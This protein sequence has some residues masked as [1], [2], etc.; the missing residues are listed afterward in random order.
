MSRPGRRVLPAF[1]VLLAATAGGQPRQDELERRL[2][3]LAGVERAQALTE[4]TDLLKND[5]PRKAIQ[6]GQEALAFYAAHPD[7]AAQVRTLDEIAWAY[8][9]VSDYPQAIASAEKGR[10]LAEQHADRKGLARALNN[11]G[12]IAQRRGDGATA[13]DLFGKSLAIYR[14]LGSEPEVAAELSN[15]G[16][17]LSSLMADY[18]QALSVQLESLALR[19]RLGDKNAIALSM[20]NIGIIYDRTGDYDKALDYFQ[21]ALELRKNSGAQNRIA[22]TLTNI[23]DVYLEKREYQKAL[24]AQEEGLMLRKRVGDKEGT[25]FSLQRLGKIYLEMGRLDLARVNF[26]D[27]LASAEQTGDKNTQANS[28]IGLADVARGQGRGREAV[29]FA[30]RGLAIA[31][32]AS[33]HDLRRRAWETLSAAQEKAGDAAGALASYK[34][35]KEENDRIFDEEKSRRLEG[36]ERRYQSQKRES[37]LQRLKGDEA[38][39]ERSA[40]RQR[41]QMNLVIGATLLLGILGF[42]AY[43]RHVVAARIAE[44]LSITDTLT[45][46]KNRRFV[47]QTIGAD[48][49]ASQRRRR[50]LRP[51][52]QT[53]DGDLVFLLIDI[54]RFKSVND[55]FGHRAGDAVITQITAVL[56]E[57]CRASDTLA[58]WGGDEFLIVSRFTNR[59]YA[60][61]FAERIRTEIERESFSL[62]DGRSLRRTCSIGFASHPFSLSHPDVLTWEQ[63]VAVA[64]E[65]LYMA[66]RAGSNAWVGAAATNTATEEQLA[67]LQQR[68]ADNLAQLVT[69]GVV[70][71]ERSAGPVSS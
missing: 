33:L 46:L 1:L 68:T 37:E 54:D 14:Q 3:A 57:I 71:I 55:E 61:V 10:D 62:G 32:Q 58:R 20:N 56:R 44:A 42:G 15:T 50:A 36:L 30:G 49:A 17:V 65:A 26:T 47:L 25:A 12:V 18:D 21:K 9:I 2:P 45:G 6:Y 31:Q 34:H 4:L 13:V 16:F 64:D 29:Q 22:A 59:R 52:E 24:D 41:F 8:M 35:F 66:K 70:V 19:E 53:T 67:Q 39:R 7:P 28:L 38:V 51:G 5:A 69:E 60:A 27:A 48:L 11:L 63:I 43:R 23:G 40:D